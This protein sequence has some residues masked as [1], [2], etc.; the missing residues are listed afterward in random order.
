MEFYSNHICARATWIYKQIRYNKNKMY[1]TYQSLLTDNTLFTYFQ[2]LDAFWRNLKNIL[3][4]KTNGSSRF[5][6]LETTTRKILNNAGITSK[7]IYLF[8]STYDIRSIIQSCII[9]ISKLRKCNRSCIGTKNENQ[10]LY[11]ILY[12]MYLCL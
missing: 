3:K 6:N 1:Q 9:V 11:H 5:S 4:I 10:S 12:I 2:P 7:N 8:I